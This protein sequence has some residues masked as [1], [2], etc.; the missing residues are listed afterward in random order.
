MMDSYVEPQGLDSKGGTLDQIGD[1]LDSLHSENASPKA[2]RRRSSQPFHKRAL[3]D[4]ERRRI[5]E[6]HA[7][8]PTTKQSKLAGGFMYTWD[9]ADSRSLWHRAKVCD[10]FARSV[11]MMLPRVQA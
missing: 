1:F 8:H 6:Y 2:I 9:I 7:Q 11:I 5:C 3:T 10:A 4:D